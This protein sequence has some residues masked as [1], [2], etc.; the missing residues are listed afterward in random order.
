MQVLL[1]FRAGEFRARRGSHQNDGPPSQFLR[2]VKERAKQV[3][4]FAHKVEGQM[5]VQGDLKDRYKCH[6]TDNALLPWRSRRVPSGGRGNGG[7]LEG[8]REGT[9]KA[10]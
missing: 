6:V 4:R 9:R 7:K 5:R 2:G 8:L 10:R 3:K 1:L